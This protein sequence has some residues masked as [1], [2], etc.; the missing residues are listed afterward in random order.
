MLKFGGRRL[1]DGE[2]PLNVLAKQLH[3]HILVVLKDGCE[4]RGRM[5]RCDMF[6]NMVLEDAVEYVGGRPTRNYGTILLRG[7]NICYVVLEIL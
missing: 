4:Y 7:N 5:V 2:K 6:M 1:Q 3:A